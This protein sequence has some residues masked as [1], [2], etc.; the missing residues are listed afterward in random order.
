MPCLPNRLNRPQHNQTSSGINSN[1]FIDRDSGKR[2]S[3]EKPSFNLN[4]SDS[5]LSFTTNWGNSSVNKRVLLLKCLLIIQNL[6]EAALDEASHEL[7][8]ILLFYTDRISKT[9]SLKI[10][11]GHIEGKLKAIQ[12]RPPI[13]L[14]A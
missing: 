3:I 5:T 14:E 4:V 6:P 12:V 8:G 9:E 13:T 7:E 1:E 2:L 11:T 10:S